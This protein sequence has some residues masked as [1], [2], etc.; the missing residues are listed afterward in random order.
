M[1][2]DKVEELWTK[3]LEYLRY[4][5]EIDTTPG[6]AAKLLWDQLYRME[7]SWDTDFAADDGPV[8]YTKRYLRGPYWDNHKRQF[9]DCICHKDDWKA[10]KPIS[11][12][13]ALIAIAEFMECEYMAS[14]TEGPREYLW[15]SMFLQNMGIE[16]YLYCDIIDYDETDVAKKIEKWMFRDYD[17]KGEGS[18]FPIPYYLMA[19]A[20]PVNDCTIKG[21]M[22][23]YIW[24]LNLAQIN[25]EERLKW[26][27]YMET[28]RSKHH[29]NSN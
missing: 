7:Y 19:Y 13:E 3:Y 14:G 6:S 12:L 24:L 17:E 29:E 21:Q 22:S 4:L 11:V 16:K 15:F 8:V 9:I 18:L 26:L 2:E 28:E 1:N 27:N 5:V 25:E 20:K 23:Q 10:Y